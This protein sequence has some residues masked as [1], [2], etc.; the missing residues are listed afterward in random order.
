LNHSAPSYHDAQ[1]ERK[2]L[3]GCST[4]NVVLFFDGT[5]KGLL[6]KRAF[7]FS[8]KNRN[9][10]FFP[11]NHKGGPKEFLLERTFIKR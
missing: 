7:Y 5:W 2:E 3:M 4:N 6:L 10:K 11:K 1:L 8:M 9:F